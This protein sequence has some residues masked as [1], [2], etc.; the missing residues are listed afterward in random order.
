MICFYLDMESKII[1][2]KSIK[3]IDENGSYNIEQ[4]Q[5]LKMLVIKLINESKKNKF[6][7]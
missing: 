3:Y 1:M 2:K 7:N 5:R 4:K 6:S